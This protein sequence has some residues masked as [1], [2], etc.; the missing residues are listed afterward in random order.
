MVHSS[1]SVVTRSL[2]TIAV[3]TYHPH[4][5]ILPYPFVTLV[6]QAI[7]AGRPGGLYG[8]TF[9]DVAYRQA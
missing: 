4:L 1:L 2:A 6:A 8:L 7:R 5:I 3:R 9:T